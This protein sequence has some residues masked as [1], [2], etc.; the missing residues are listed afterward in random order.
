M[1]GGQAEWF[2]CTYHHAVPGSNPKLTIDALIIYRQI[3]AIFVMWKEQKEAHLK[4]YMLDPFFIQAIYYIYISDFLPPLTTAVRFHTSF[5]VGNLLDEEHQY[6]FC[7]FQWKVSLS[8]FAPV[9]I[10]HHIFGIAWGR[11]LYL[12]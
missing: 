3:C 10:K 11:F 5:Y 7:Q 8:R 2:V 4:R 6:I 9:P 12:T 1:G